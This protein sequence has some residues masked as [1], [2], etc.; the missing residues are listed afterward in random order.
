[1]GYKYTPPQARP[2]RETRNDIVN[3]FD[4]WNRFKP[5]SVAEYDFPIPSKVGGQ[6]AKARFKLNGNPV[7]VTCGTFDDY[8]V[9]L[10][11]VWL[12]IQSMRLAEVR[13]IG[14]TIRSAY[15]ALP[16]PAEHVDPYQAI[17]V[18]PS[19]ELEDIEAVYRRKANRLGEG[20]AGLKELNIAI[21]AIREEKRA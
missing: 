13:G 6:E 2:A 1:M 3:E 19:M 21:A 9:N 7:D 20:H 12:A 4:L 15:A 14:D 10:R 18:H 17:G 11:C 5:A 16:A 8:E